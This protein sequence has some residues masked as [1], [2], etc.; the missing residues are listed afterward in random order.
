M[1]LIPFTVS[2][3]AH[4]VDTALP[5]KLKAQQAGVLAWAIEGCLEWQRH[6]L[7]PPKAVLEAT[8]DY[9]DSQDTFLKRVVG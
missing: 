9:L 8:A 5:E 6:G 4:E 7:Q 3:P 2:I 1:N